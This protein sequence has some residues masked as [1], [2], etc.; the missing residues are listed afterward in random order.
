RGD[1]AGRHR[2][3]ARC[4]REHGDRVHGERHAGDRDE[5]EWGDP[6]RWGTGGGGERRGDIRESQDRQGRHGLH[7]DGD[8]RNA[9]GRA[10]QHVCHHG[11][12][13]TTTAAATTAATTEPAAHGGG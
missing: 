7:A 11:A 3:C 6:D 8:F 12:T 5:P 4:R 13:T 1:H 10:E 2:G 9:H